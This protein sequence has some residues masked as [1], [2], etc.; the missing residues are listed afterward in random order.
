MS[1]IEILPSLLTR[2]GFNEVDIKVY[3]SILGLGRVTIGELLVVTGI[4]PL[5]LVKSTQNLEELGFI[6]KIPGKTPQY[7]AMLPYLKEFITINRDFHYA[8]DGIIKSLT[9]TKKS[10]MEEKE[11]FG[12]LLEEKDEQHIFDIHIISGTV[13]QLVDTLYH[14]LI[15]HSAELEEK[16]LNHLNETIEIISTQIKSVKDLPLVFT[17][18]LD[19]YIQELNAFLKQFHNSAATS[20]KKLLEDIKNELSQNIE[21]LNSD[22]E[23]GLFS[24]NENHK[25]FLDNLPSNLDNVLSDFMAQVSETQKKFLEEYNKV[26]E[27]AYSSW[28]EKTRELSMSLS[29]SINE[30][31]S[32]QIMETQKIRRSI[33]QIDRSIGNISSKLSEISNTVSDLSGLRAGKTKKYLEEQ[34]TELRNTVKTLVNDLNENGL[35]LI[36][37]HVIGLNNVRDQLKSEIDHFQIT[38]DTTLRTKKNEITEDVVSTIEL[39]P[40]QLLEKVTE[41]TEEYA[42]KAYE[43]CSLVTEQLKGSIRKYLEDTKKAI[44]SL[45]QSYSR[46][47]LTQID[48]LQSNVLNELQKSKQDTEEMANEHKSKLEKYGSQFQD[49]LNEQQQQL[50]E[51]NQKLKQELKENMEESKEKLVMQITE[52]EEI[53]KST[54]ISQVANVVKNVDETLLNNINELFERANSLYQLIISREDDLEQ[55]DK[56]AQT[57]NFAGNYNTSVI[58]G[59]EAIKASITDIAMRSKFDLLLVTPEVDEDI[60]KEMLTYTKAQRITLVSYFDKRRN[61]PILRTLKERFLGLK[62]KYYDKKDVYCAILDGV[63]EAV[64]AFLQPDT[65][66]IAIRTTNELLLQLFKSAINRDVLFHTS[67]FEI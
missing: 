52:A 47:Q 21:T 7:F 62:L 34:L 22:I 66:P 15:D 3:T 49:T 1:T 67:D 35:Q 39:M 28:V 43:S 4:D 29:K 5:T 42:R 54:L 13:K 63:N 23:K 44:H 12:D 2:I 59:E 58:V 56:A 16:M 14:R 24:H 20:S 10:Y 9:Q 26:W 31:F 6:K 38:S 18:R 11:K 30:L 53:Q 46:E 57:V 8:I 27:T 61:L 50:I 32:Q 25:E 40:D 65:I 64:F 60:L 19:A 36:D 51:Q 41:Q 37:E 17:T 55:I 33:E 45:V 48:T